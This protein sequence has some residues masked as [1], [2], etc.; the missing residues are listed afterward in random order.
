MLVAAHSKL[1]GQTD[2]GRPAFRR[3]ACVYPAILGTGS[4]GTGAQ[5]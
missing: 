2:V 4:F 3:D 5:R 1:F